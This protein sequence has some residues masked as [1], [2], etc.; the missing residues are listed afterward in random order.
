VLNDDQDQV[1]GQDGNQNDQNQAIP[2]RSNEKIEA[3]RKR[4]VK[5]KT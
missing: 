1:D 3:R 4:R 2:Q 5:R